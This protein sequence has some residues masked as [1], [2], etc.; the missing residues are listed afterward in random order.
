MG[1]NVTKYLLKEKIKVRK[2]II[3]TWNIW[4]LGI[5]G[6][7]EN[8]EVEIEQLKIDI[9]GISE[10]KWTEIRDFWSRGHRIVLSGD[11]QTVTGFD[12]LLNREIGKR[13]TEI[14]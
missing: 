13:I 14:L 10:L 7:L 6:K 12:F 11:N 5:N 3:A 4:S 9:I 1:T 2:R 8:L